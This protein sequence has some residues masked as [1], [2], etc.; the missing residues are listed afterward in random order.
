M[1]ISDLQKSINYGFFN[2]LPNQYNHLTALNSSSI[3]LGSI[4]PYHLDLALKHD[5]E[6]EDK[7]EFDIGT[8]YH[9]L[10]FEPEKFDNDYYPFNRDLLPNPDKDLKNKENREYKEKIEREANSLGKEIL[11]MKDYNLFLRMKDGLFVNKDIQQ[12]IE[13]PGKMEYSMVWKN[14]EFNINCK[15]RIDKYIEDNFIIDLKTIKDIRDWDYQ[16][17][18]YGYGIQA[19][20]YKEGY[21]TL[22]GKEINFVFIVQEKKFPFYAKVFRITSEKIKKA[23]DEYYKIIQNY[24][25]YKNG[26]LTLDGIE[27]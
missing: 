9:K 17:H 10:I 3:K 7:K 5:F 2:L 8:G 11:D 1:K 18:K 4:S 6:D 14:E 13:I 22:T 20:F 24:L 25:D 16:Y 27:E 26:N 19:A 15:A 23:K 12:L 21:E